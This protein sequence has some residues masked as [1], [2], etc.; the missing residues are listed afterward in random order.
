VLQ[1]N[2][3]AKIKQ[4]AFLSRVHRLLCFEAL[5]MKLSSVDRSALALAKILTCLLALL[6]LSHLGWQ[7]ARHAMAKKIR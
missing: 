3:P 7:E 5:V 1:A 2:D 6:A 4:A